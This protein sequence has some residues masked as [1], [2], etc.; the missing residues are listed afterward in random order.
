MHRALPH[1]IASV[2]YLEAGEILIE[3]IT[4]RQACVGPSDQ[5]LNQLA[6]RK[7]GISDAP[8]VHLEVEDISARR[9]MGE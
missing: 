3:G 1:P 4:Q 2:V 7:F 6:S 8:R 9:N 5:N